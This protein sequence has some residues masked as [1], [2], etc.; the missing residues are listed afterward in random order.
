M[1]ITIH[2]G[3]LKN[4]L[5]YLSFLFLLPISILSKYRKLSRSFSIVID[6][7]VNMM[8]IFIP[9]FSINRFDRFYVF[10]NNFIPIGI[11][12]NLL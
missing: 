10:N 12:T 6:V 7:A 8:Y 2:Q 5:V 1:A 4:T 3:F 11:K 9:T